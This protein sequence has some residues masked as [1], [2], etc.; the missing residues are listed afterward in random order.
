MTQN[1]IQTEEDVAPIKILLVEDTE[2]DIK[3][4]MR[5]FNKANVKNEIHVVRDGQEA[6]DYLYHQGQYTD[7]SAAPR[8]GLILLD[9][10]MPRLSG[11]EVLKRVKNDPDLRVIPV[12][13]L[14]SS[15][16]EED[17]LSSYGA[18]AASYIHKPVDYQQFTEVV[19]TFNMYWQILSKLPRNE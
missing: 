19:N 16:T 9:I 5:A 17:I 2:A 14:T 10:N 1:G 18:G 13:M 7:A 3:I 11:F 15:K 6:L 12:I 4:T 8:P